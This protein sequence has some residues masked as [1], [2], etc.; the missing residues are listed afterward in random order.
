MK[1]ILRSVL[2]EIDDF[3][4]WNLKFDFE[5]DYFQSDV[6][7]IRLRLQAR[8]NQMMIWVDHIPLSMIGSSCDRNGA[9]ET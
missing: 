8:S 4:N 2:F 7:V 1:D 9:R 5:F 3:S 6:L